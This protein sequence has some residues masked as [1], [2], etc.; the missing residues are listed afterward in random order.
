MIVYV[1][2]LFQCF[3]FLFVAFLI[4]ILNGCEYKS[5]RNELNINDQKINFREQFLHRNSEQF[6]S[7]SLDNSETKK[8]LSWK[9]SDDEYDGISKNATWAISL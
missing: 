9:V 3:F 4:K 7:L 8:K 2:V 5:K 6:S 1:T